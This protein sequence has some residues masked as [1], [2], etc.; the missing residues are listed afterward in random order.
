M[1]DS[2]AWTLGY[3]FTTSTGLSVNALGY[4]N[5]GEGLTHRGLFLISRNLRDRW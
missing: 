4:W 2:N 1:V 5:D 3:E